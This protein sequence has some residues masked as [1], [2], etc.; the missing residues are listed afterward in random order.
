MRF[1]RLRSELHSNQLAISSVQSFPDDPNALFHVHGCNNKEHLSESIRNY[2][3]G[4][5]LFNLLNVV[6][7]IGWCCCTFPRRF[8]ACAEV[9]Q[10]TNC[11]VV[12][13]MT[14]RRKD[15]LIC[16]SIDK[17]LVTF[18]N[19]DL[20]QFHSVSGKHELI[21][22][23]SWRCQWLHSPRIQILEF[24]QALAG[25]KHMIS[26]K[27]TLLLIAIVEQG[28]GCGHFIAQTLQIL[29]LIAGFWCRCGRCPCVCS[30]FGWSDT[31]LQILQRFLELT[32][33][34]HEKK[35]EQN[36]KPHENSPL[37]IWTGKPNP[38]N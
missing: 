17:H 18:F 32:H 31:R 15:I 28:T 29:N 5:N 20:Q 38:H 4:M 23:F 24:G 7:N 2:S 34:L 3:H 11:A 14:V 27:E 16:A 26:G 30:C 36:K 22:W 9:W 13:G 8:N 37:S 6:W 1:D 10:G 35:I 25:N 19:C 21:N 33:F 12:G